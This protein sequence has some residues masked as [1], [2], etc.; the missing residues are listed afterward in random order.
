MSAPLLQL[1]IAASSEAGGKTGNEDAVCWQLPDDPYLR[2]YKGAVLALADGVSSAEAG[3]EASQ[4][5]VTSFVQ[6]YLN[7]P[8]TWSVRQSAE[9]VLSTVNLR[10]YRRSH[11]FA[12]ELKGHL[13]TFSAL[14]LK[15]HTAYFFHV[16]DSRIWH[17]RG[18]QLSQLS[19][20]HST[21]LQD[22]RQFLA[23]ALG[24]SN[25][26]Q[27]DAGRQQLQP[28]DW[29]VLSSDGL[30][31]FVTE[32]QL[33][34]QLLSDSSA[35]QKVQALTELALR[36]GSDDNISIVL[37]RVEALPAESIDDYNERL[38]R[39]PFPPVLAPGMKVDGYRIERELYASERSHL[40]LV[41]DTDTEKS[42]I[43]KCPSV[44]YSDDPNYIDRFIR[45]EWIGSRIQ[46]PYVVKVIR[47]SRPRSFLY[48]LM[49]YVQGQSLEQL[50]TQQQPVKPGRAIKLVE[51]IAKGLQAFHDCEAIHQD[52]KPGNILVTADDQVKIV[53]FGSV[54]V[55]GVAEIF[56]PLEHEAAL[57][58]ASYSDPLYLQGHNSGIQGDVY[59]L[60]TICYELFTGQLP[61]GSKIEDCRTASDFDRLRYIPA[62]EHNPR[63]P[64][65]FDRA[66]EKGVAFDLQ[67]RYTTLQ[68]LLRDLK[69]PNPDFL[70]EEV[71][72]N[73]RTSSLLFWQLLSGFWFITLLLVIWLFLLQR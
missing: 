22:K 13:C 34:E 12:N 49:E 23:R 14:V 46:S 70:R 33:L 20:D 64:L 67:Q 21:V 7:T 28:G 19:T 63:I 37:A 25:Q 57:G 27:L 40:Y 6:D 31:D 3:R 69:Q 35:E 15:S 73:T 53:D 39:L 17:C 61:Y 60:A 24:M 1:T 5:A 32:Q 10:L 50:L 48:Y 54:F 16:G 9:Q 51:Q 44:N 56:V 30:H 52:L 43:L 59:S 66:L 26:L 18:S 45:E 62:R 36:Q 4:T 55:A 8:D 42:L 47:Q 71:K 65:W 68:S 11:A 38:T 72:R 2:T 41:T 58:T 29:F